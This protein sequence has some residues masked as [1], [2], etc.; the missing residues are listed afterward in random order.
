MRFFARLE[1]LFEEGLGPW[2]ALIGAEHMI[3]AFIY[4]TRVPE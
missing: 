1:K 4:L 3:L 2:I